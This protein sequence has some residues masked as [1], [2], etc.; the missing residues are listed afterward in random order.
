MEN[1]SNHVNPEGGQ[2]VSLSPTKKDSYLPLIFPDHC[3]SQVTSPIKTKL[4]SAR[5]SHFFRAPF[6][7]ASLLSPTFSAQENFP[8][9]TIFILITNDLKK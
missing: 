9:F 7:F 4:H 5:N 1:N 8:I 6:P 2:L 3:V